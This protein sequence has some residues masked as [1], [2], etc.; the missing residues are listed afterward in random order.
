MVQYGMSSLKLKLVTAYVVTLFCVVAAGSSLA[1]WVFADRLRSQAEEG[2]EHAATTIRQSVHLAGQIGVKSYMRAQV[3]AN[4]H[5]LRDMFESALASGEDM[6]QVKERA[7]RYLGSQIVGQEGYL[8]CIDGKGIMLMHPVAD[9]VGKDF[10][11]YP[12]IR[13]QIARREGYL[14]YEWRNPGEQ[15]P[16]V[17]SLYMSYFEP[18]DW[19]V[20][21]SGY[22]SDFG[23]MVYLGDL[24]NTLNHLEITDGGFTFLMERNGAMLLGSEHEKDRPEEQSIQGLFSGEM[25]HQRNGRVEYRWKDTRTGSF[26]QRIL[27]FRDIPDFGWIVGA[28]GYRD[29]LYGD[30]VA[31]RRRII[32]M[33][34]FFICIGMAGAWLIGRSLLL[35]LDTLLSNCKRGLAG[36]LSA[37]SRHTASD[38]IGQL[39]RCFNGLMQELAQSR[40]NLELAVDSRT[41]ELAQLNNE[42]LR[43]INE[44]NRIERLV[45]EQLAFTDTLLST[46]PSPVFYRG[47][48]GRFVGCNVSFA[49][50]VLG[51]FIESV[52]G[53]S[54]RDFPSAFSREMC[55]DTMRADAHI[56]RTGESQQSEQAVRCADG[57]IRDFVIEKAVFRNNE[58]D[59]AGIIGVMVDITDRKQAEQARTLLERAVERASSAIF[60]TDARTGAIQYVNCAFEVDTGFTRE[61]VVGRE[62]SIIAGGVKSKKAFAAAVAAVHEKNMWAG[63]LTNTRKNGTSYETEASVSSI[64]DE[65]GNVMWMVFVQNNITERVLMETKLLQAQKLESIGLLAAGIAHEINTPIQFVGDNLRFLDDAVKELVQAVEACEKLIADVEKGPVPV[66]RLQRLR[67]RMDEAD[68]DFIRNEVPRAIVQAQDGVER[69]TTIVRAMKDYS[70]PGRR[71]KQWTNVNAALENT[72]TVTRN[73]WKYV[74]EAVT[75]LDPD[76]PEILCLAAELNQVFMNIIVNAAHAIGD[77]LRSRYS[78]EDDG[79]AAFVPDKGHI[80]IVTAASESAVTIRISDTGTGIPKDKLALIFDPFFTTKEVGKG[81]GQGLA[82]ARDIIVNMHGGTLD[83]ESVEG[84]GA[85]F[86]I[87]LPMNR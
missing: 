83:V 4:L 85:T 55:R 17:K 8:Y 9:L 24:G 84:E 53:K 14:E 30:L 1:Y 29:E 46:I 57:T 5:I 25:L 70:H 33:G 28:T 26:R 23:Q 7:K 35:P 79:R 86:T 71:E 45:R 51:T 47:L 36:D 76:L 15:I 21:V 62:W 63:R 78:D 18:W 27:V 61:E 31:L 50:D 13:T 73:E 41:E 2:I 54:V 12:F 37:R 52:K 74:A 64:H 58:G 59:A 82:I 72:L 10:S 44:K 32:G 6:Q 48:D 65:N 22:R 77:K 66:G 42:Y 87:T 34:A 68:L 81:T 19:I 39:A 11:I 49:R 16:R 69:V 67:A 56:I 38:E 80:R 43:E 60:I 40:E 75:E 20:T 3:E